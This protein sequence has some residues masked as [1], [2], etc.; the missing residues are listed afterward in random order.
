MKAEGFSV[1]TARSGREALHI[2]HTRAGRVDLLLTDFDMPGMNGAALAQELRVDSPDLP[3]ILMSGSW[4]PGAA[5]IST[6][7][8][9]LPKP[10]SL[11]DLARMAHALVGRK[12]KTASI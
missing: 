4:H 8:Q 7:W 3:V 6:P 1:L 12:A 2:A 9:F 5:G 11:I 10:F